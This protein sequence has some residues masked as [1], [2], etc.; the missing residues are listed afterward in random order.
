MAVSIDDFFITNL[1]NNLAFVLKIDV[2]RIRVVN[3][4]AEDS[5]VKRRRS[6]LQAMSNSTVTLEFGDPPD[7]EVD[8]PTTISSK[9]DWMAS[10]G[11]SDSVDI[12]VS[13]ILYA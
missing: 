4:I 12:Q 2:S 13:L 9:D 8:P 11:E 3:I 7:M 10:D 1:I 5:V 6:L